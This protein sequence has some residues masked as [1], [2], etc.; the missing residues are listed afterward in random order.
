M[1][2]LPGPPLPGDRRAHRHHPA[3]PARRRPSSAT[4]PPSRALTKPGSRAAGAAP[5]PCCRHPHA[6][7][8]W[9]LAGTSRSD[10]APPGSPSTPTHRLLALGSHRRHDALHP[11]RR[12]RRPPGPPG[13]TQPALIGPDGAVDLAAFR[14][15]DAASRRLGRGWAP[16]HRPGRQARR[17]HRAGPGAGVRMAGRQG[18]G[19]GVAGAS[20]LGAKAIVSVIEE[21]LAGPRG[22]TPGPA[23]PRRGRPARAAPPPRRAGRAP[24]AGL[25]P[26]HRLHTLGGFGALPGSKAWAD[27]QRQFGEHIYGFEHRTFSESPSTTPC[28]SWRCCPGA[29]APPRHPFPRGWWATCCASTPARQQPG[30][31]RPDRRLPPPAAALTRPPA[32]RPTGPR[33]PARGLGRGR[34]QRS[35]ASWSACCAPGM[36]AWNAMCA[37]AARPGDLAAHRQPRHLPVRP[38]LPGPQVRQ[39]GRPGRGRRHRALV[40]VLPPAAATERGLRFLA[41]CCSKSPTNA[42]RPRPCRASRRCCRTRPWAACSAVPPPVRVSPGMGVIAGDI[43]GGGLLKRLGVMFTDAMFFDR[44]TTTWWWTPS[45]YGG[46]ACRPARRFRAGARTSTTSATS[47]TTRPP[48]RPSPCPAPAGWLPPTTRPASP[49]GR[50][51]HRRTRAV[52]AAPAGVSGRP[53]LPLLP[54]IMGSRLRPTATPSGSDPVRLAGATSP[55]RHGQQGRVSAGTGWWTWPTATSAATSALPS[56]GGAPPTGA[57]PSPSSARRS[58]APDQALDNPDLPVRILAHSMGGLVVRRPGRPTRPVGQVR[59]P[60]RQPAGDA[61]HPQQGSHLFVE[62]LL[63]QSTPSAPGPARP[64]PTC[65]TSS[66]SSPPSPA[67][68]S[69]CPPPASSIPTAARATSTSA[70]PGTPSPPSTTT[71][72]SARP[73][74][75]AP[76]RPAGRGP[77]L[78]RHRRHPLGRQARS[79]SPTSSARPT[80]P[81]RR[82]RTNPRRQARSAS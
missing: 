5:D 34:A 78:G 23:A 24:G 44:A 9:R 79:A 48:L 33:P 75:G 42:S 19:S 35:S 1:S 72:G 76:A 30:A 14:P 68:S 82:A 64:R 29:L 6:C 65:R 43:E 50:P 7:N 8:C 11:R 60:R 15:R 63:G 77:R 25:H 32:N 17:H 71:S 80:T 46:I 70:A 62:T 28:S 53:E 2:V 27:L 37:S 74:A 69:C 10:E 59:R 12:A 56:G 81:L 40:P 67:P 18:R 61:R 51:G 58:P 20:T 55:H 47:A 36:S 13:L 4:P 41:G 57:S 66:T 22:C 3:P 73:S 21:R 31:R 54:G 16:G 26:R 38:V 39:P 45:M 52:P 49:T